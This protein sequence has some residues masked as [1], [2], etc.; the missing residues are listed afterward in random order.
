[1]TTAQNYQNTQLQV[2]AEIA[3]KYGL[4]DMLCV[5]YYFGEHFADYYGVLWCTMLE[6]P[7]FE[8]WRPRAEGFEDYLESVTLPDYLPEW[9]LGEATFKE[10]LHSFIQSLRSVGEA[11]RV[12]LIEQHPDCSFSVDMVWDRTTG[13]VRWEG[14]IE[15]RLRSPFHVSGELG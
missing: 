4:P 5:S 13:R 6:Q 1:M 10:P 15:T 11:A 8:D 7:S 9:E 14:T 12:A 3:S 2:A